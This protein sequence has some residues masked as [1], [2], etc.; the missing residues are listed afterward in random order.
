MTLTALALSF[1]LAQATP[2]QQTT[3]GDPNDATFLSA[4]QQLT[5]QPN[6][7]FHL[8]GQTTYRGKVT[9]IETFFYWTTNVQSATPSGAGP[10]TSVQVCELDLEQY[11]NSVLVRRIVG[12]GTTLWNYDFVTH[13]YSATLYGSYG[14][15]QP[16][17]YE[18]NLLNDFV[19]ATSGPEAY[20]SKL[21]RQIYPINPNYVPP[22]LI[23][24]ITAVPPITNTNY[25]S[26]MPGIYSQSL[27][28]GVPITFPSDPAN[29]RTPSATDLYYTYNG[30]PKRSI[31]FELQPPTATT[32]TGDGTS[33]LNLTDIYFDQFD[34][35]GQFSKETSW[36]TEIHPR[37]GEQT[38]LISV[39]QFQPYSGVQ[40][41]GWKPIIGPHAN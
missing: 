39:D 17:L 11:V 1:A 37:P 41:Q 38:V 6:L 26:W 27:P 10:A 7:F 19:W 33:I 15:T 35:I 36:Y 12:D 28:Q 23:I 21:L 3:I 29:P 16:E 20:L 4:L 31:T 24:N 30:S 9:P 25:A 2:P 5:A 14:P 22:P 8:L 34:Q 32:T 13:Q 18:L 40:L